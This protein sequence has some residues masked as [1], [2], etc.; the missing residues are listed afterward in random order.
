M[1]KGRKT[2]LIALAIVLAVAWFLG[3]TVY[4]V[5]SLGIH[6]LL[7]LAIAAVVGYFIRRGAHTRVT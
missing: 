3:F 6:L 1:R 7:I 2:M 4:H 5:A